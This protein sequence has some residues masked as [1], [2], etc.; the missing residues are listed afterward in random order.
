[1]GKNG[2]KGRS[3]GARGCRGMD[4]RKVASSSTQHLHHSV[5]EGAAVIL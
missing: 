4:G 5:A 2:M 3:K 1:M